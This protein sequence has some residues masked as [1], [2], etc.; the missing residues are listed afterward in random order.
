MLAESADGKIVG[1]IDGLAFPEPSTGMMHGVGQHMY[2]SPE[3]RNTSVA[4]KI[5]RRIMQVARHF[6]VKN[7]EF[8]C[9]ADNTE[10]WTKKGYIPQR[11]MMRRRVADV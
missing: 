10:L 1:F 4:L 2:I 7:W 8:F 3:Y 11:I 5:Y 9:A 6:K